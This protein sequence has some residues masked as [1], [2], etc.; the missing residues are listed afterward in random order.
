M[1]KIN[2]LAIDAQDEVCSIGLQLY[3]YKT[4]NVYI[5]SKIIADRKSQAAVLLKSIEELLI[6]NKIEL[7]DL[8][9]LVLSIG[10]GRFTG[11][12]ISASVIQGLAYSL[13]KQVIT[14][15]SLLL[16]AEQ[17]A[18][19][20][21]RTNKILAYNNNLKP[22]WV[23]MKAYNN[24]YYQAK[25]ILD[26]NVLYNLNTSYS[27]TSDNLVTQSEEQVFIKSKEE[28][29]SLLK[30]NNDYFLVGSGWYDI[31]VPELN[32]EIHNH[33]YT[34]PVDVGNIFA[35]ANTEYDANNLHSSFDILPVYGVNPYRQL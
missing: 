24:Y 1:N 30:E 31:I 15:N 12:R 17:F 26:N 4:D 32:P 34:E 25:F 13:N 27:A 16:Y 11:L 9:A 2:L 23:C 28:I 33:I 6:S 22:I 7:A 35:L 8:D 3:D 29:I 19:Q 18:N 20:K 10:P 21:L 14:I 5:V